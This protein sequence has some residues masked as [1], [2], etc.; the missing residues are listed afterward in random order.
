MYFAMD[1]LGV[2]NSDKIMKIASEYDRWQFVYNAA[3]AYDFEGIHL[4]PSLYASFGLDLANI[5]S[6]FKDFNLS[7]H[8][9]GKHKILSDAD[10]EAFNRLMD[11]SFELAVRLNM[12]DFSIHPPYT[13]ECSPDEK[14]ASLGHFHKIIEKWLKP[15]L[16]NNISL[17]LETHVAGEFVLFNGLDEYVKFIDAYPALGVLIDVS[18]N[19]YDGYSED[20]I[21]RYFSGKNVKC[22]HLSDARQGVG[23][24]EGTHLPVGHGSIDFSKLL[25]CFNFKNIPD[26]C[27]VLEMRTSKKNLGNSLNELRQK[28]Y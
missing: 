18:N 7:Y 3:V 5:P 15:A 12:H 17:S 14:E 6:Y 21:I 11:K 2:E 26:L 27:C 16:E 4:T 13:Y 24:R 10:R 1:E 8:L 28:M 25:G 20:D 19:Y 9:G 22:L 23:F